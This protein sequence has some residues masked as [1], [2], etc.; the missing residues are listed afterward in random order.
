MVKAGDLD[1]VVWDKFCEAIKNPRLIT[2]QVAKL[3]AIR[4]RSKNTLQDEI[5]K[6]DKSLANIQEEENR[7]LDAYRQKIITIEKLKEQMAMVQTRKKLLDEEKQKLA[8]ERQEGLSPSLV[9]KTIKDYCLQIE[10][11]LNKLENDFDGKRHLVSL[12]INKV[13]LD[14]KNVRIRGIIPA[15]PQDNPSFGDIVSNGLDLALAGHTASTA[16]GR[17]VRRLLPPP[18]HV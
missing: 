1:K 17:C 13:I 16:S 5:T 18:T 7:L 15:Y 9:K 3:D 12:A 6:S 4:F 10:K 11:R 2:E 14:G 8:T